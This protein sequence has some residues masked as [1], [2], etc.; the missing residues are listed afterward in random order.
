MATFPP[1][2]PDHDLVRARLDAR[3][4]LLNG[5]TEDEFRELHLTFDLAQMLGTTLHTARECMEGVLSAFPPDAGVSAT[6]V[7]LWEQ[8]LAMPEEIASGQVTALV[9][10][11]VD[12]LRHHRQEGTVARLTRDLVGLYSEVSGETLPHFP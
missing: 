12:Q 3:A 7:W 8:G 9:R 6:T 4:R 11:Y 10:W 5:A 2:V 1:F